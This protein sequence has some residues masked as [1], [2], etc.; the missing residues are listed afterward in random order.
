MPAGVPPVLVLRGR[1]LPWGART[2]IMA[3]VNV[4]PDSFSGDGVG[5][6]VAAALA[7]ATAAVAA[8]ADIL[9]VGGESTRPGAT[10]VP[11]EEEIARVLP[12]IRALRAR[13]DVPI[14][15]DTYKAA[16]AE[17]ALDAGADLVND[18]WALRADP[19]MARLVAR[20]GV[21]VVLMHNRATASAARLGPGVGPHYA[22]VQ[23]DDL[24]PDVCR[25]LM[26]TVDLARA[27]GVAD[28]QVILDPGLGFGKTPDQSLE[29]MGRLGELRAL[30]FPLLV[31]P[32][33]KSFIGQALG[34]LP[35]AE[36]LE[37][38]AAAVALAIA[39]GADIVRVHDVAAMVRVARVADAIVRRQL[40]S[41][42]R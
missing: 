42:D 35:P 20:R 28:A 41:H 12:V 17:A 40:A 5:G 11:G 25:E 26:A 38:S 3:I 8:G 32:S 15:V 34:G 24:V 2:Y 22:G 39:G 19:A 4:T 29:L 23:Y 30:G 33:R 1:A 36:R 31:G 13:L 10:A 21:P 14:S 9:D 6:D 7:R 16:V 27:A 37:G 18:V